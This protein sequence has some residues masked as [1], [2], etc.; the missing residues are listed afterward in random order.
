MSDDN[1]PSWVA[2][3]SDFQEYWFMDLGKDNEAAL[4]GFLSRSWPR[5]MLALNS[6]GQGTCNLGVGMKEYLTEL[7]LI[8]AGVMFNIAG[9][10]ISPE[11]REIYSAQILQQLTAL[12]DGTTQVCA[13][14]TNSRV[15]ASGRIINYG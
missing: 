7:H 6:S 1:L 2:S 5:I 3:A 8:I 4:S 13:G 10:R 14:T 11:Q 9:V 12:S 15:P